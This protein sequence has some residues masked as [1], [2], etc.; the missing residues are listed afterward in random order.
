MAIDQVTTDQASGVMGP[1]DGIERTKM[2]EIIVQVNANEAAIGTLT[3]P[4]LFKGAISLPADFPDPGDVQ[5]GWT[6]AVQA[7]VV[8]DD[9]T[10]TNTGQKFQAG[11]E[12]AW[13]GADWTPL[14]PTGE[15][16][17]AA[18]TP[19]AV[20]DGVDKVLV[21]TAGIGGPSVVELPS[22]VDREGR[23]ITVFDH[24]QGATANPCS[25]TPDG[26]EAI[27]GVAAAFVLN[28]NSMGVAL[29]SDGAGWLTLAAAAQMKLDQTHRG[30]D[31][32]DHA[33]VALNDT[34]RTGDGTDHSVVLANRNGQLRRVIVNFAG[35]PHVPALGEVLLGVTTA[36]GPVAINL[37]GAVPLPD[38][39]SLI[40]KDEGGNAGVSAITVTPKG[41]ETIDGVAAPV[42]I[43]VAYDVLRL[44]AITGGWYTW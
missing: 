19:Y 22:A 38:G 15:I 28:E 25:V 43:G 3:G 44:Y 27:D 37:P 18:A 21:D 29:V 36:G 34:H 17:L 39:T 31:G 1:S 12:I 6:Y 24:T 33:N 16:G 2:N 9:P 42:A 4:L 11:D 40:I 23:I 20:P 13:N 8:D 35:S 14:G 7:D 41:A 30:G 5:N 10:K 32:S 26:A